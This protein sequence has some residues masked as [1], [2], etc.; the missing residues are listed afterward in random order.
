MNELDSM[1]GAFVSSLR[2]NNKQIREDRAL[3]IAEDAELLFKREI[4]DMQTEIKRYKRDRDNMLDLAGTDTTKIISASDFNAKAF[5]MKDL[6]LGVKIRN[7][8]IKLEIATS[9]YKELFTNEN[10][11]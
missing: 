9:R 8:E 4:E 6:E 3:S 10:E 7:L 1:P 2:R 11:A 5:V